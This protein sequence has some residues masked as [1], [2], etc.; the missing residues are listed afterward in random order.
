MKEAIVT[1]EGELGSGYEGYSLEVR[2]AV[3]VAKAPL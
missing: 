2:R 3:S 1:S